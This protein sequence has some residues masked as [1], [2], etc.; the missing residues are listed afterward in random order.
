M[1]K[2]KQEKVEVEKPQIT[3][4]NE[5][6]QVVIEKEKPKKDSWEIKDRVYYLKNNLTPLSYSIKAANIYWFDE[7]KGYERELKSTSNQRTV[8]VDEM[9]GEFFKA[10]RVDVGTRKVRATD[11]E[12]SA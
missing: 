4:N 7:E 3:A 6:K 5:M 10:S 1:A 12:T 11:E 9:V 2:K 8:F